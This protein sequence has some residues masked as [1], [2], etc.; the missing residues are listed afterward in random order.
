MLA[1]NLKRSIM[2]LIVGTLLLV[3][4]DQVTKIYIVNNIDPDEPVVI[5][6][7]YFQITNVLNP[8]A[9]FGFM[10]DKNESFRQPFFLG[11]T[12]LAV[13]FIF[14]MY[15]SLGEKETLMKI[16]LCLILSGAVGNLIDRIRIKAVIDFICVH[17]HEFYW[18]SFNAADA[19]ISVG[20]AFMLLDIMKK[21]KAERGN[22]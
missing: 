5:I 21:H 22:A 14:Y 7:N 16:A 10:A 12:S 2:L 8:G 11:L 17:Y 4:L 15:L 6:E 13:L 1:N 20:V 19:Y 9:A 18:P 3:A